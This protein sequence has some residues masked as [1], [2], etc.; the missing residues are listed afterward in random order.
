MTY[1]DLSF[2][3]STVEAIPADHGYLLYSAVSHVLPAAHEPNSIALHPIRGRALG[4]R[5][6]QLCEWSRLTIRTPADRIAS[7]LPLSGKRL[8]LGGADV[9]CRRARGP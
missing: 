6:M 3:V 9:A 8:K 4:D 2:A 5:T 7:W 1:V